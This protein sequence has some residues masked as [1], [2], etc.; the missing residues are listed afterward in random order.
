MPHIPR[1]I[2][3]QRLHREEGASTTL[4]SEVLRDCLVPMPDAGDTRISMADDLLAEAMHR[5]ETSNEVYLHVATWAQGQPASTVPHRSGSAQVDLNELPPP[6]SS[7]FLDGDGMILVRGDDCF[8]LPSRLTVSTLKRYLYRLIMLAGDDFN[9]PLPSYLSN[10]QLV[11]AGDLDIL[12]QLKADPL[13][14]IDLQLGAYDE[15]I[16][17]TMG[18]ERNIGQRLRQT[19]SEMFFDD[20]VSQQLFQ[21]AANV[22]SKLNI[23]LGRRQSIGRLEPEAMLD[24]AAMLLEDDDVVLITRSGK[25]ITRDSVAVRTKVYLQPAGK[26]VSYLDAWQAMAR[27]R[28]ELADS[29]VI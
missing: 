13:D 14:Q 28:S 29:G 24:T 12:S 15:D 5:R 11:D 18:W 21:Q 9:V 1:T 16:G 7:D 26:S 25:R 17:E 3:Y 27:Y 6:P 10:F 20:D 19:V 4:L 2:H 8:L 22:R 23:K